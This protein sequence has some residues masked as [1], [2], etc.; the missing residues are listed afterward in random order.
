MFDKLVEKNKEASTMARDLVIG[1]TA[2]DL[3]IN[4]LVARLPFFHRLLKGRKVQEDPL[5]RLGVANAALGLQ[6]YM[7]PDNAKLETAAK[8][9]VG[10]A[11]A[12]LVIESEVFQKL[13]KELEAL[14]P[15]GK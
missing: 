3:L 4:K 10:E 14:V 1:K 13:T 8:A 11:Q 7:A 5:V 12:N 9:M 15:G 6:M 2:N